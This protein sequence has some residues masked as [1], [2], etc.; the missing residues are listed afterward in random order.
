MA[1]VGGPV[2]RRA[3]VGGV[4][5]IDTRACS[6]RSGHAGHISLARQGMQAALSLR[7][8]QACRDW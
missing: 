8:Q 2:Q 1:P 4:P 6:Q 7:P 5:L 3:A